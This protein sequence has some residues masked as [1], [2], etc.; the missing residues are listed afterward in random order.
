MKAYLSPNLAL[1]LAPN[2][3]YFTEELID[4]LWT[5]FK[6]FISN[7][8]KFDL[9]F[10][11]L[12]AKKALVFYFPSAKPLNESKSQSKFGLEVSS[13]WKLLHWGTG[14]Y[15][16]NWIQVVYFKLKEIWPLLSIA[17]G[18]KMHSFFSPSTKPLNESKSQSK[19][20]LEV[21]SQW[22]L[23]HWKV[24][25]PVV[26]FKLKEIWPLFAPLKPKKNELVFYESK[27]QSKF[28]LE[29]SSQWKLLH[30][31]VSLPVVY[32][33]LK[34]IWP[35][36]APLKPKKNELVF[37]WKQISVQIWPWS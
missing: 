20:G 10:P 1:K 26:Y 8:K 16:M 37:L 31:K 25:L 4:I 27:S 11:L 30:W 21:S 32:F 28:G 12:K 14:R 6:L 24:S 36:F 9:Y 5:E 23:L 7:W 29:V 19:F 13:Q 33:K 34:E 15:L 3:N 2:K 17:K 35:L 22:K 18:K